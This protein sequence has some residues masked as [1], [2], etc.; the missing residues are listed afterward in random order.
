[1][2]GAKHPNDIHRGNFVNINIDLNVHGVGGADTWGKRTLP[3]Y[4]IDGNK[5][6]KYGFMLEAK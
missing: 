5:A 4:T 1:M 2:E 3:E 6:W